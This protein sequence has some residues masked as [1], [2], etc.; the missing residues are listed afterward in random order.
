VLE[1]LKNKSI[2][3]WLQ[4]GAQGDVV[5]SSR[6]RLARNVAK[7]PFL[8]RAEA[9]QIA[10]IE[11]LVHSKIQDAGFKPALNYCRLD[12]TDPFDLR[13]LVERHIIAR[14][15]AESDIIRAVAFSSDESLSIMINEEDHL[16]MQV[17]NGGMSLRETAKMVCQVDDKIASHLPYAF[18][19]D[20]GFLTACPTNVGTGMRAGLMLHLPAI[21]ISREMDKLTR[22]CHDMDLALR[23]LYGEGTH[24][25]ADVYQVSNNATLGVDEDAITEHVM[26]A[27]ERIV[28]LEKD[29]R[30]NLLLYHKK[31]L[32][33]RIHN[34]FELLRQTRAI[35]SEE[36]LSLLSQVR[37]GVCL[38][39]IDDLDE[40][41]VN[42]LLFLILPAHLQ[43]VKGRETDSLKRNEMRASYIKENLSPTKKN[44]KRGT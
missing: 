16:R 7:Y 10:R 26:E 22:I 1:T 33:N 3:R 43:T 5:L 12:Q 25:A 8:S 20:Y 36:A 18:S 19:A 23:G 17:I 40:S 42:D 15:H 39:L 34:A 21:M 2:A 11:E 32:C 37:L 38:G 4:G 24:G 44:K 14:D 27:G 6:V 9:S 28:N 31:E 13:L 29:I 30:R 41:S 35:S